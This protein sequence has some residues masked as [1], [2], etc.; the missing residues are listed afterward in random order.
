M[1]DAVR[2]PDNVW[3]EEITRRLRALEG[4]AR[5]GL[6][7]IGVAE[8]NSV[9]SMP[10]LIVDGSYG[11][12][13]GVGPV[14]TVETGE[15]ALVLGMSTLYLGPTAT[16]RNWQSGI[17]YAVSGATTIV[18]GHLGGAREGTMSHNGAEFCSASIGFSDLVTG[19]NRGTNIFSMKFMYNAPSGGGAAS[20][21]F[22]NATLIVIPL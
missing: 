6:S 1:D 20:T 14:V 21:L 9:G 3:K 19:L 15:R 12:P 22:E 13:S 7:K 10:G 16:Y 2:N 8:W 11:D 17:S 5:S 4:G 18:A